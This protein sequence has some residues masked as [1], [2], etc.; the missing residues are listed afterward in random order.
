VPVV[1]PGLARKLDQPLV[2]GGEVGALRVDEVAG[3]TPPQLAAG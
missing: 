1:D 2:E 3:G